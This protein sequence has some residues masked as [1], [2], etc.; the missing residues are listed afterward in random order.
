[1]YPRLQP[2]M[3]EAK[4]KRGAR[5]MKQISAPKITGNGP[6]LNFISHLIRVYGEQY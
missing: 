2:A 4:L 5:S 1:M 3:H 6:C